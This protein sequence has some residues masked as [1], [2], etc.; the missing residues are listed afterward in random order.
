M[1]NLNYR[2]KNYLTKDK[3]V[4]VDCSQSLFTSIAH[5]ETT[6]NNS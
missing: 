4:A 2:W 5:L 1:Y 6:F 3:S